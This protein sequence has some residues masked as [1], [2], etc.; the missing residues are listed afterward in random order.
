M[1]NAYRIL[2]EKPDE[3]RPL[4]KPRRRTEL[5]ETVWEGVDWIRVAQDRD[6]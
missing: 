4:V 1:R 5:G 2:V 6:Q 3:K